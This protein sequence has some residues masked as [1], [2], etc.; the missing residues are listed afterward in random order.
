[1]AAA[2]SGRRFWL[3]AARRAEVMCSRAALRRA[4]YFKGLNYLID[5]Q[6]DQAIEVFTRMADVDRGHR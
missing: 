4:D 3:V 2:A 1:M 6:P 5:E